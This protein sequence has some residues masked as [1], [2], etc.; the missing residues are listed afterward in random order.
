MLLPI[1]NFAHIPGP[2]TQKSPNL[3]I[4]NTP[5]PI[6]TKDKI[7]T[8]EPQMP[9][10]VLSPRKNGLNISGPSRGHGP[11]MDDLYYSADSEL[12]HLDLGKM[13]LEGTEM[14]KFSSNSSLSQSLAT[15]DKGKKSKNLLSS[16]KR[17]EKRRR[18]SCAKLVV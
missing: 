9:N 6:A 1:N 17:K 3:K 12:G 16:S 15:K 4:Y 2:V 14:Y 10:I 13:N 8:L 7:L 11:S 5:K 18:V